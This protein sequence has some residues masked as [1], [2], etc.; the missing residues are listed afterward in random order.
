[1]DDFHRSTDS[2]EELSEACRKISVRAAVSQLDDSMDSIRRAQE[3]LGLYK[4]HLERTEMFNRKKKLGV[5]I[6]DSVNK[7]S[8][9][10]VAPPPQQQPVEPTM[11]DKLRKRRAEKVHLANQL[12]ADVEA[13]DQEIDWLERHPGSEYVMR[14]FIREHERQVSRDKEQDDRFH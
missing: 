9:N 1:M 8:T 4:E 12:D 6:R 13:L 7:E 5:D 11:V 3:A 10:W 2:I 14:E